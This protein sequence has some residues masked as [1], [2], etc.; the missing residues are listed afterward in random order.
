MRQSRLHAD[1]PPRPRPADE[2][3]GTGSPDEQREGQYWDAV[4]HRWQPVPAFGRW[5]GHWSGELNGA[6]EL[7]LMMHVR[8]P[9]I[10]M[11]ALVQRVCKSVAEIDSHAMG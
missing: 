2:P 5:L 10:L 4:E 3:Q 8:L 1:L 7:T 6:T 9:S 11:I